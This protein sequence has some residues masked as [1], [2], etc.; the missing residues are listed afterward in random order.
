MTHRPTLRTAS[1]ILTLTTGVAAC[2]LLGG[3]PEPEVVTRTSY[4][5]FDAT[6]RGVSIG[7]TTHHFDEQATETDFG[8]EYFVS[9]E[10]IP[11]GDE[12]EVTFVVDSIS[13]MPGAS[14][15]ISSSQVDSARGATFKANLARNGSITEFSGHDVASGLAQELA[16]RTLKP[17]FPLIPDQGAEAGAVWADTIE[18]QMVVNGLDTSMRLISEHSALEWTNRGGERALHILT[19]ANYEFSSAGTQSGR[20]FT[21][22]GTGRRHIHRYLSEGGQYLGLASAD[23][24]VGEAR[25]IDMDMVIPIQQTRIDS[26]SIR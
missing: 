7:H 11:L 23:T 4:Q 6:Y 16:D 26:I 1:L 9:T 20:D 13:M 14:G 19:V 18:T 17:F 22:D 12:F 10:V 24:S 15:G 8:L 21:I 25:L 5:P 2:G 3:K